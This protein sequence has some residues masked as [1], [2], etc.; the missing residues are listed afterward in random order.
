MC[1]VYGGEGK[2]TLVWPTQL[3]DCCLGDIIGEN[4]Y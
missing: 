2:F 4:S 3:L 1:G